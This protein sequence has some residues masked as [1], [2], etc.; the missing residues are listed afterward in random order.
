M[1]RRLPPLTAVRAFEAAARH[2]SFTRAAAELN[3]TQTAISHQI[4]ALEERLGVRLFRRLPRGL[5]L[6]EQAQVYLPDVRDA[7]DRIA[8]ATERLTREQES[9]VLT[10]S[11]MPSFAA[12]WLVPRLGRLRQ[13]HPGIDL[14][15]SATLQLVDFSRDDID[16]AVRCGRGHYPGLRADRLFTEDVFPV[17]SPRLLEGPH[18]LRTP[19]D[20]R[21]HVL[22]H[23]VDTGRV[24]FT[25]ATGPWRYWLEVAGVA[26][27][28]LDHGLIFEDTNLLLDAAIAGHGVALGRSV[29]A[30]ADIAAGRLV[31]PF[32]LS[33]PFGLAYYL[34]YPEAN[35]ER[36]RVR[37][38]RDWLLAEAA[39]HAAA[40]N[41]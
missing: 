16:V 14:R 37:A 41:A 23:D 10:V 15:I 8:A 18:P 4:K 19:D 7:L 1:T 27:I 38:F 21:H 33:V 39:P 6:T 22:L 3:V 29:I 34:V 5:V 31:R 9:G 36:P 24:Q 25:H 11:T 2:L 40:G 20:L 13:S 32:E 30:A 35:A 28:D 26:G 12:K 17:C